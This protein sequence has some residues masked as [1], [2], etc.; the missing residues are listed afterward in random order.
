[1]SFQN[2]AA[3]QEKSTIEE[4]V[5]PTIL[6]RPGDSSEKKQKVSYKDLVNQ[7]LNFD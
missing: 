3:S 2:A 1:M 7:M 6:L 5:M 4:M